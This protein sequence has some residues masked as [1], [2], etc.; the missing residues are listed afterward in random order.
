M[1]VVLQRV[2]DASVRVDGETVGRIGP[3]LLLLAAFRADD[4]S[5]VLEWMARKCID[6]RVFRDEQ[7]K[8]N[9]SLRESGGSLLV[10]SQFTLYGDARK[11]RRPSFVG[12]A[13]GDSAAKLYDEFLEACRAEG[14]PVESGVFAAD[15]DVESTNQGPV[16]L[17]LDREAGAP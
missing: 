3:G 8:M 10:I 9:R 2:R 11:G 6:L 13:P 1:R 7:G 16:T 5:T 14:V 12:S 4:D 15:M 17:I